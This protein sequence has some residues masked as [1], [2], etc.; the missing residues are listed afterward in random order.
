MRNLRLP[1]SVHKLKKADEQ[2]LVD[3]VAS[4]IPA[5]RGNF[6]NLAGRATLMR[7][8]CLHSALP[9]HTAVGLCLSLWAIDAIDKRRRGL[10]WTGAEQHW[11]A[12]AASLGQWSVG[13]EIWEFW[14]V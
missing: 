9:I 14:A 11:E 4:R 8:P 10:L 12:T 3:A 7:S 5:W 13:H 1:L 2:A 6:L